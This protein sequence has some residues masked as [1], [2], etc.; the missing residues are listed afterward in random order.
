MRRIEIVVPCYN[1]QECIRPL[2]DRVEKVFE[3]IDSA[4]FS[5]LYVND[6]SRD[7]TLAEIRKLA[8]EKGKKKVKYISFARNFGKE[9]G[10]YAGL[11]ASTGDLV[12]LMDADLQ[13]PP[14][15]LIDM[16]KE[17]DEGGYDC[18][19]ARRVSRKGEPP[20]RSFFSHI[21]YGFFKWL[22][23][24]ELVPGGSDFR[25]M[26]RQMVDAVVSLSEKERFTKGL[27]A[28]VGF[29]TK[30]I[31][32]EN[33]ERVAG[34]SKWSFWGLA[35]YALNGFIGFA[36][37]PLRAVVYLGLIVVIAAA[38]YSIKLIYGGLVLH[39]AIGNGVTTVIVLLTF[40]S[41]VIITIL[42][43]IGEYMARIYMELKNRPIYITKESNIDDI[44]D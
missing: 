12:V 11:S 3:N 36:T 26:S 2:Y 34:N 32:Y 29:D 15:I 6:G 7:N 10:I 4:E 9:S 39:Q 19:G 1:E 31:P 22:T 23:G 35:S 37:T 41:G 14:E 33:V 43:V 18:C 38:I 44:K 5:L 17:I 30:W 25:M 13:H 40:F 24:I 42:G 21:F 28:W 27:L 20:I 8:E 16:L